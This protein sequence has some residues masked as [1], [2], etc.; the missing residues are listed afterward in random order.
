MRK[1]M[2][3]TVDKRIYDGLHRR[4]GKRGISQFIEGLVRPHVIPRELDAAYREMAGDSDRET[5][6]LAWSEELIGDIGDVSR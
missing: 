4:I 3:I 1:K 2:T 6:A 5:A